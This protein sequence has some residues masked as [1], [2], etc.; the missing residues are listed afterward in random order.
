M[1]SSGAK[2]RLNALG[3]RQADDGDQH[4]RAVDPRGA[5]VVVLVV[6]AH[7]AEQEGDA[8]RQQQVGQ[9]GADDRSAHHVEQ[10]ACSATTAM[11]SSGALP[12]VALSSPPTASPV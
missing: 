9:D 12:N 11:I 2:K 3:T 6:E 5:G 1:V 8:E 7:P 4:H 10:P